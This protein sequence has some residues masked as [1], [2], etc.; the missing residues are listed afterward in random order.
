MKE[1]FQ[2]LHRTRVERSGTGHPRRQ[3][4][5]HRARLQHPEP[6]EMGAGDT[7]TED[8][9]IVVMAARVSQFGTAAYDLATEQIFSD[10]EQMLFTKAVSIAESFGKHISLLVVPARDVWSAIVQTANQPGIL[11]R[12]FRTLQQDDR[13][14]AG[15]LNWDAPGKPLP[16]PSGSS[17]SRWC[18]PTKSRYLPYRPA[19]AHDEDGRRASG[20]PPLAEY[21]PASPA[22]ITLHHHDMLTEALT[23]FA[24]DYSGPER[25]RILEELRK[26]GQSTVTT[27]PVGR[28]D[29]TEKIVPVDD[30]NP[31]RK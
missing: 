23:R 10:Y 19:H 13:P 2:L 26:S 7:D 4:A 28:T 15:F 24:R 29:A 17:C 30:A 31:P 25:D 22:W 11:R 16:S 3:R 12:G 18:V 21:H 9:D 5:G 6:S 20:P 14:G 8:Q 1:H 27:R